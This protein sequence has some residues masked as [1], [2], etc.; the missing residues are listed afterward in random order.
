M[1]TK[2]VAKRIAVLTLVF[3]ACCAALFWRYYPD[4]SEANMKVVEGIPTIYRGGYGR[5]PSFTIEIAG[6][7]FSCSV[8]PLRASRSCPIHLHQ[9]GVLA[10]ATFIYVQAIT[11]DE[12]KNQPAGSPILISLKQAGSTVWPQGDDNFFS[13]YAVQSVLD[14]SIAYVSLLFLF[15]IFMSS[16]T[17]VIHHGSKQ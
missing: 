6:V 11:D 12:V 4:P 16:T 8:S 17:K 14:A 15:W 5:H 13:D 1:F 2:K 9:S 10:R 7:K 3:V